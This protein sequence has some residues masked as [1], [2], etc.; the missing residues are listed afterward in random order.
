MINVANDGNEDRS[1]D[2]LDMDHIINTVLLRLGRAVLPHVENCPVVPYGTPIE[3]SI[4][5]LGLTLRALSCPR[6]GAIEH[7]QEIGRLLGWGIPRARLKHYVRLAYEHPC[8]VRCP[9]TGVIILS[10]CPESSL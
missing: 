3:L 2:R 6:Q 7:A 8:E 5:G 10:G 1:E 9:H 4:F